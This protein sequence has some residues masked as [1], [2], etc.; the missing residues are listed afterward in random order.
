[1]MFRR[2]IGQGKLFSM[3][4]KRTDEA[5]RKK[6]GSAD[7]RKTRILQITVLILVIA[8]SVG[9]FL[10][11]DQV[12]RLGAFGYLGAFLIA[13]LG[14]S[15]IVLPAPNWLLIASLGAAFNPFLIGLAAAAGGT[16]GEMAGYG[17]GFSGRAVLEDL[18]RYEQVVGWMRRWG[19]VTIFVLALI[20]N[21][22]FDVAGIAAGVLKFPLWK[23]IIWGFLG[24]L[25]KSIAYAYL[26][27]WFSGILKWGF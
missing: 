6:G 14:A 18:P 11:R 26:G 8:I 12:A 19:S 17:L 2:F 9:I 3:M 13:I 1:M 7:K 25:P 21:P 20:P 5:L 10:F 15:T 4:Q 23:Y 24:R 27:I 16:I 22:L